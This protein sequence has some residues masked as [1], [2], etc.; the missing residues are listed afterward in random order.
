MK[1]V[2]LL[3]TSVSRL[4][5]DAALAECSRRVH[6]GEGGAVYFVNVHTLTLATRDEGLRQA[7]REAALCLADGMPLVWLARGLRQDIAS[8]VYGPYFMD[9]FLQRHPGVRHGFLGGGP[10]VAERLA[11]KYGVDAAP[12]YSPPMRAFSVEGVREDWAALLARCA[13]GVAPQVLW[14]GLGAPKQELWIREAARL[15][16]GT[17]LLGVGAAFD[18]LS[19]VKSHA[20]RWMQESGLA[21]TYRL[22]SEPRRLFARY[23]TSNTR[24]L[25]RAALELLRRR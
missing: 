1:T 23:A 24:F 5:F 18:F 15:A 4:G 7:F 17:L 9:A 6:A 8:R 13:G 21:W 20:P 3:G 11:A 25:V 22:A 14:V 10:G 2:E 12:T 16:P 19:G